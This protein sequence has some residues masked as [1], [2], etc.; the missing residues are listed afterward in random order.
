[1]K[2]NILLII[3][4]ILFLA[5][6]GLFGYLYYDQRD[7]DDFKPYKFNT[8]GC[9]MNVYQKDITKEMVEKAHENNIAVLDS[10]L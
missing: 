7:K 5:S 2:K 10:S 3:A 1:M 8:N 6:V 4:I 9:S